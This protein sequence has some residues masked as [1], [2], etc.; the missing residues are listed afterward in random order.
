ME[1]DVL[2]YLQALRDF[3]SRERPCTYMVLTIE[4]NI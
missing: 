4:P 1:G 2:W 3:A